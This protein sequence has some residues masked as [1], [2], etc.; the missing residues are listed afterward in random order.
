MPYQHGATAKKSSER[1]ESLVNKNTKFFADD[2]EVRNIMFLSVP[3]P[4]DVLKT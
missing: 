4:K 2:K 3:N 1:R